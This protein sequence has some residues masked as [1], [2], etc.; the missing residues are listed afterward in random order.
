M[1]GHIDFSIDHKVYSYG[2][3][4]Y[5]SFQRMEAIG[6]G[7]MFIADELPYLPFCIQHEENTIFAF[8]LP[9]KRI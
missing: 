7:V 6:D 8:G 9:A 5:H 4:D 1:I 2:K 3:Y